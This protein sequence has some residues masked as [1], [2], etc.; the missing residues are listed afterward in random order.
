V[1]LARI[2]LENLLPVM[3]LAALGLVLRRRLHV[4][5]KPLSQVV[6]YVFAPALVFNL[7]LKIPFSLSDM[8]RMAAFVVVLLAAMAVLA[9]ILARLLHLNRTMTSA[10]ILCIVFMNAGNLGLPVT[11]L[12]FGSVPLAWASVFFSTTALLSNSAGAWIAS[13]GR[14]SPRKALVG[15]A[16]VPAVYAIPLALILHS[17][18]V[19][20]PPLVQVPIGLLAGAAVPS[21]LLLLGMQ[22]SGNGRR[23]HIGLLGL[24]AGMRLVV[25]P[26]IAWGLTASFGLPAAAV[27]A[28]ILEAAMPS[29][30]LNSILATQYDVEPDFVSSAIL[31]TTLLSPLTLTPLLQALH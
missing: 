16:K 22:L 21:M 4:D 11:Q 25:S 19:T 12:A 23:A 30:V 6:F 24:V 8:L 28:G 3:I 31:V 17:A 2:F 18:S 7:L 29:A 26:L 15:L 27:Q 5:P 9:W 14:A 1:S 20:L 10:L 13:V